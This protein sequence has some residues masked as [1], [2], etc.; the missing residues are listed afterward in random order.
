MPSRK[1]NPSGS[2]SS[3]KSATE[4]TRAIMLAEGDKL[5]EELGYS[6]ASPLER[7]M[8]DHI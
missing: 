5:K 4:R 1:R 8:I 3:K 6:T 2:N 7:L